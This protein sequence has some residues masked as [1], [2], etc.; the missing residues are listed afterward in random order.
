[1]STKDYVYC[2]YAAGA[3]C[4][5]QVAAE[6]ARFAAH[7]FANPGAHHPLAYLA[8]R[9]LME[10]HERAASVLGVDPREIVFTSGGTESDALA[11]RGVM[12]AAGQGRN[13][14]VV[15]GI[16][17]H[18]VLLEAQR[19]EA[20]GA[21]VHYAPVSRDGVVDLAALQHMVGP[22]TA[23]VSVMYA[24]N[25]TGVIQPVAQVAEIAHGAGARYHCDAVQAFGKVELAPREIG[26]DLMSLAAAKFGGPKGMGLLYNQMNS[27]LVPVVVGGPQ[28]WGLRAGTEDLPGMAAMAVAMEVAKAERVAAWGPVA[29]IRD[30]LETKLVAGLGANVRLNG[31]QAP[32]LP[33]VSN[34][35]FLHIEGQAMAIE[36]GEQGFCVGL[37][38]ACAPGET[39]PSHVL[40]AM[41]LSWE[42]AIGCIRVSFGPDI[43][44]AQSD[45]LAEL[46]IANYTSL[47]GLG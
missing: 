11:L 23:L 10:V 47:R 8:R 6:W 41:G 38:S 21:V 25:E 24:N 31:K 15:S 1:M 20:E 30:S 22:K 40:A 17:H 34:I 36:L 27:R 4:R 28:E 5:P 7:E 42:D 35:S 2:D 45:R 18:A 3:P 43:T 12:K 29:T 44:Q 13:E 19:L 39:D 46:C 16:E 32:R 14:L 9:K 33:N 37:G 26:C